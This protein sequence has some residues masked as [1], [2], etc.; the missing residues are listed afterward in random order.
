MQVQRGQSQEEIIQAL[1]RQIDELTAANLQLREQLA[2]KEQLAVKGSATDMMPSR[3]LCN[4][5]SEW[6]EMESRDELFV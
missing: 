2:R 1:R 5:G 3:K 4:E 6:A